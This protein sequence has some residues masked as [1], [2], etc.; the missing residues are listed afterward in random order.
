MALKSSACFFED[1]ND[2]LVKGNLI[3]ERL[4]KEATE[5]KSC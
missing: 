5:Q 3:G 4:T 1:N 2:V